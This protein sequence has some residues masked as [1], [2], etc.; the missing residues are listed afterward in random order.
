MQGQSTIYSK[1]FKR[2]FVSLGECPTEFVH[3]LND[4]NNAKKQ[5]DHNDGITIKIS[6]LLKVLSYTSFITHY[7]LNE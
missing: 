2:F 5:G 4:P 3:H 7:V 6:K 1:C